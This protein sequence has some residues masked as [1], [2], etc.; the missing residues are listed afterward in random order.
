MA[1]IFDEQF[2]ATGYDETSAG[3]GGNWAEALGGG[4]IDE[5]YATSS[6]TG[7]PASWG[8]QCLRMVNANEA[9]DASNYL[10]SEYTGDFYFRG[11]FIIPDLSD[12]TSTN[13]YL[14]QIFD[15]AWSTV[16]RAVVYDNSG[17]K[18]LFFY[19]GN[20]TGQVG[21]TEIAANTRYRIDAYFNS[22][23]GDYEIKLNGVS[24]ASG[25]DSVRV[26]QYIFLYSYT[27]DGF[28]IFFDNIQIA[29]DGWVP[30]DVAG[31]GWTGKICGVTNP[32][33]ICGAAVA[34]I[35]KVSGV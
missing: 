33:K 5:D 2:E 6:V 27:A 20:V 14:I 19:I 24:K 16:W 17:T 22:T 4:T 26:S 1:L 15:S 11:D 10:D 32:S 28:E 3:A 30:E 35:S 18:T 9:Q 21:D 34:N 12:I 31:G 29:T 13:G 25:N 7:A 23:T 8:N